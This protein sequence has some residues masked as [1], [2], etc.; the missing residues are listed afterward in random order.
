MDFLLVQIIAFLRPIMFIQYGP[1]IMGLNSFEL[2]GVVSFLAL[3][4]MYLARLALVRTVSLSGTDLLI[5]AFSFWCVA[6]FFVY[7]DKALLGE[8]A[9][10]LIPLLTF[11]LVKYFVKSREQHL[12]VISFMIYGFVVPVAWTVWM[13][14]HGEGLASINYWTDLPRYEGV[15]SNPHNLGH[16]MAFLLMLVT[17]YYVLSRTGRAAAGHGVAPPSRAKGALLLTLSGLAIFCLYNSYVRTT[18]VGIGIFSFMYLFCVNRKL[19]LGAVGV[20]VMGGL[21]LAPKIATIFYDVAYVVEGERSATH[22]G[23]NRPNIWRNNIDAFLEL[24]IDRKLAGVGIGNRGNPGG[25]EEIWNSHNDFLEVLMQTGIVG[26]ILFLGIQVALLRGVRR[27]RGR[28][29]YL[30]LSLFTTVMVM[31]VASNS[32]VSRF[33]LAAMYYMLM[34]YIELPETTR[35]GGKAGQKAFEPEMGGTSRVEVGSL[36]QAGST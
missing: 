29:R 14:V 32:Y 7:S 23:S 4:F 33:G 6:A 26:L 35:E 22:L 17:A 34:A 8:L 18:L 30:F 31:N 11:T 1:T 10:I 27:L 36:G 13:I 3:L 19:W 20:A 5:L 21:A 2:F 9:K 28:E 24:S 15:Y 16:N 12:N 25:D